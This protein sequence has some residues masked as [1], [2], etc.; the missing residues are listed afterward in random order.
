M[1][2]GKEESTSRLALRIDGLVQGVGFRPF[3]YQLATDLAL[4]GW[5]RNDSHG[6]HIEV[7]GTPR[8]LARFRTRLRRDAPPVAVISDVHLKAI[9]TQPG[10]G[11]A[12]DKSRRQDA[13]TTLIAPDLPT[14]EDCLT[15]L[16]DPRDRRYRYP[17]INCT[18]CGPRYTIAIGTPYD[19]GHTTMVGFAMCAACATEFANPADRRFH[20]Q[21]IACPN[22][23][24]QVEPSLDEATRAL[25][26]GEIVAIKGLGGYHLA[27]DATNESAVAVLRA[28]KY[29]EE[30]PFAVM[31]PDLK[32]ARALV[33][34]APGADR[35]LTGRVRPVVLLPRLA[36]STNRSPVAPSVAP[37]N[38]H[39]GILLPYTPLHHLLCRELGFPIVLTSGNR[40]D[41]PIAYEDDDASERLGGIADAFVRHDRPIHIRTDDGVYRI[42]EGAPL[43]LRRSRGDAPRPVLLPI[44]SK[45]PVLACG[46]ELKNSI[47]A[48]KGRRAFLSHHIGDLENYAAYRSFTEAIRHVTEIFDIEPTVVAHDLHP[49]YLSTKWAREQDV[50]LIGVQHHHAHIAACL[51]DN[52]ELGPVLGV[53]FDGLGYGADGTLWG[54]EFLL[55]DCRQFERIGHFESVPMPGGTRA[56]REPWRMA[57]AYLHHAFGP[58]VPDLEIMRR[59][60]QWPTIV[61]LA[62][63]RLQS[64]LTSSVGR[65]F[66]AVSALAIGKDT[67]AYE[68]QAAIE[69]EQC[70]DPLERGTYPTELLA[71]GVV[72]S[73]E[74]V[75]R[76]VHDLRSGV[77]ATVVAARFHNALA[78]VVVQMAERAREQTGID[79][80]ALSGGVFQNMLLLDRTVERLRA[81]GFRALLHRQVPPNDGGI[82]L[83]QAVV[84]I[85][86]AHVATP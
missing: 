84:A 71:H 76:V 44:E 43:V 25:R 79:T 11:F 19:R 82:S 20:A 80:A 68:G 35:I 67:V 73:G 23:G 42:F 57:A 54:G 50:E 86:Q 60:P 40:S 83:G 64:P 15:E 48:V 61:E 12:I 30:K 22:C 6:V 85:A 72:S 74:I 8:Q 5:V 34:V 69:L 75:R 49:E 52:G 46:A 39:L 3:V 37:N 36:S 10:V 18:N 17:F 58:D 33:E 66:D 53:A 14:C 4:S 47:C 41:E 78:D 55:A 63:K 24:P 7:Q 45:R 16:F 21:P 2:D 51:A 26:E 81:K 77:D 9:P 31:V 70:A 28:R 59:N 27:V 29:R 13:S 32:A 38:R 65:L 1:A 56:I 62:R